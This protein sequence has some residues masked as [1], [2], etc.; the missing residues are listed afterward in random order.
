MNI[1]VYI[2]NIYFIYLFIT[3]FIYLFIIYFIKVYYKHYILYFVLFY[4]H[5][6]FIIIKSGNSS[7]PTGLNFSGILNIIFKFD[8]ILSYYT[9]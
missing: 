6:Y 1:F 4:K 5:F 9:Y 7:Y 2:I 8:K 3:Y